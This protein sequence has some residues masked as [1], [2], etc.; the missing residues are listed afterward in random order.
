MRPSLRFLGLAVIGWASF[1]AYT[2]GAIPGNSFSLIEPSEAKTAPPI[3]PTEFPPIEPLASSAAALGVA[4]P[5]AYAPQ[6]MQMAPMQVRPVAVPVYYYGVNSVHVPLPPAQPAPSAYI[7]PEPRRPI[8]AAESQRDQSPFST[9]AS[10]SLT[11]GRSSVVPI[12]STPML[13]ANRID[14]VQVSAWALVRNQQ[15]GAV[16]P[17][18]LASSGNLGGSQAG[19][20]LTYA[21]S[22]QVAASLRTSSDIGRRGFEVAAGVRV[23]PLANIPVWLTAERRQRVGQFGGRNAFAIFAEGGVYDRP[24]P[25]QFSL[26]AYLQGG[27]VGMRSRDPFIDGAFAITRPVYKNFSGGFGVW[28]GAQPGL[29]RVDA[30]PRVTMQVRRNVR[31]HFDWRQRLA[32]NALPGSGPAITLGADF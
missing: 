1:R 16:G 12:Q 2:G 10:L 18:S 4:Y 27:V 7:L 32:G 17:S 24:L 28:G 23:Q 3:V 11:Q 6:P 22:R 29:Y 14:R 13:T 15:A 25:W 19:A 26:D 31:V 9:I 8:Y 5:D 20:R 21:F 30:G